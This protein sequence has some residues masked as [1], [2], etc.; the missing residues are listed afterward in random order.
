M[1]F[2]GI[3][4]NSWS[5]PVPGKKHDGSPELTFLCHEIGHTIIMLSNF[6]DY[7]DTVSMLILVRFGGFP[8]RVII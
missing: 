3:G 1:L 5:V 8:A 7:S 2:C 6:T 4:K